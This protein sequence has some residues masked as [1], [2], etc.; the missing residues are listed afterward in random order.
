MTQTLTDFR[1][2]LEKYLLIATPLPPSARSIAEIVARHVTVDDA[3]PQMFSVLVCHDGVTAMRYDFTAALTAGIAA[4]GSLAGAPTAIQVSAAVVG[5][6]LALRGVRKSVPD[7]VA[8]VVLALYSHD[9]S[10]TEAE[11]KEGA[12]VPLLAD[13][14]VK[15]AVWQ[16]EAME[17][18]TT[19]AGV[20]HLR[21]TVTAR[22]TTLPRITAA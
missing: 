5:G 8:R 7:N 22:Y 18:I 14:E 2:E 19:D 20:V 15:N 13:E 3:R 1:C 6:V 12:G 21:E 10:A 17:A 4:I 11:I 9:G 16:L